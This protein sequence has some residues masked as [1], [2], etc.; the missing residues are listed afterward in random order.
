MVLAPEELLAAKDVPTTSSSGTENMDDTARIKSIIK[1]YPKV[2]D[3]KGLN[4][5]PP[6]RGIPHVINT[7]DTPPINR[8]PYRM[9]PRELDELKRQLNELLD[10]GLIEP[11]TSPWGAPILFVRK[12]DGSMRMCIDYRAL[13]KATIRNT[14]PLPRI[15]ECLDRLHGAKFFSSLD[16]KSGYHQIRLDPADAPKTAMNTRY[17]KFSWRVLPFGLANSPPIFQAQMNATLGNCVDDFAMVY[18]DDILIFSKTKEEH[19]RHLRHVLDR[20]KAAQFV[21]NLKKC[22]LFRRHVNFL[23]FKVSAEGTAPDDG[24]VKAI[25]SWPTPTNVQE[26]RQFVGMVQHFRRYIPNFASIAT[27]LTDLTRGTG[28]KRRPIIWTPA[29]QTSFDQLKHLLTVA[30]VL[31]APCMDRPFRIETDASDFGLGAVLSQPD[32]KGR[33]HPLAY[34]SRKFSLEERSYPV[35][36]RELLAI[37]YALRQWRGAL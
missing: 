18:L 29:W 28:A 35:Q 33:W 12:K 24:K 31:Q 30:P 1:E 10:L 26:V 14:S 16:L 36:E 6:D 5:L 19:E 8:P 23:G 17:G 3:T 37:L 34:E 20:L 2:F 21:V 13:N 25:V 4:G 11:S 22:N 9:S 32:D 15:D 7:G 27:P